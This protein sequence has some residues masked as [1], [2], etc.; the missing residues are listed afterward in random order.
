M[1]LTR[2][3]LH[4]GLVRAGV[5]GVAAVVASGVWLP[6]AGAAPATTITLDPPEVEVHL[7]PDES[8]GE[9][10]ATSPLQDAARANPF[11]GMAWGATVN[12]SLPTQFDGST[13]EVSLDL[14][15]TLGGT[16]TRTLATTSASPDD[17]VVTDN[18]GGDYSFA[19]PTDDGTNGPFGRLRFSG[20]TLDAS[21][22][23]GVSLIDP[24]VTYD[25]R[26]I[27]GGPFVDLSPQV[28]GAATVPCAISSAAPCSAVPVTAGSSIALNITSGS[29]LRALGMG[30][31]AQ[32]QTAAALEALDAA[33]NPT[34]APAPLTVTGATGGAATLTVP[35]G[36][37]PG[38]YRLSIVEGD[39]A[40]LSV[41][42]VEVT[43]VAAAS[44]GPRSNTGLRSDTGVQ[45]NG[46]APAGGLSALA[47]LGAA[48][49]LVAGAGSV[50]VLRRRPS[51]QG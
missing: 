18:G 25:L 13:M 40:E 37:A 9:V 41:T 3:S 2:S 16:P 7:R 10:P 11:F 5:A 36:T 1:S 33:G 35:A 14:M 19:T 50:A 42:R 31:L 4:R 30:D 38:A 27:A 20:L 48:M 51:S 39:G 15:P 21:I 23:S 32:S 26:F 49:V 47:P 22:P 17:L 45:E 29:L 6:A 46:A 28:I 24:T 8:V 12:F 44:A 34:G 43:V